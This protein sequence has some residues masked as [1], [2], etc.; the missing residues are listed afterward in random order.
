MKMEL[1]KILE[2]VKNG[3]V[4]V[5]KSKQQILDLFGTDYQFNNEQIKRI[6]GM[7]DDVSK[8]AFIKGGGT[9]KEYNTWW[10]K[11]NRININ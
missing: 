4:E 1:N 7:L 6:S 10:K 11:R 5:G 9:E 3:K 8:E 2:N